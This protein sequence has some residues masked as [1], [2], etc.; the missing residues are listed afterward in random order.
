M[1]Q[2][3]KE[4]KL[5]QDCYNAVKGAYA[6]KW[7][8]LI[9]NQDFNKVEQQY[10]DILALEEAGTPIS[11]EDLLGFSDAVDR[12]DTDGR[13]TVS[14]PAYLNLE[15]ATQGAQQNYLS[16]FESFNNTVPLDTSSSSLGGGKDFSDLSGTIDEQE[17]TDT[18]SCLSWFF[19]S[20]KETLAKAADTVGEH[21]KTIIGG[22]LAA[23][24]LSL[25]GTYL[26]DH[27]KGTDA[28]NFFTDNRVWDANSIQKGFET[29]GGI[30][31]PVLVGV[32]VLAMWAASRIRSNAKVEPA[33]QPSQMEVNSPMFPSPSGR[34]EQ[35]G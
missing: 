31:G 15:K 25:L 33:E 22:T 24:G 35:L 12:A 20:T 27:F 16:Q 18:P 19:G 13:I 34:V 7:N 32:I 21:P 26:Y 10:Q 9:A 3:T 29:V 6:S 5:V 14:S 17:K 11:T 2:Q 23:M 4:F 30:Y 28:F 1:S 8:N